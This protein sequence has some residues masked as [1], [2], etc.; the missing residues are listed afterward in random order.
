MSPLKAQ[1]LLVPVEAA[2]RP[3]PCQSSRTVAFAEVHEQVAAC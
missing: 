3:V 2:K 1:T